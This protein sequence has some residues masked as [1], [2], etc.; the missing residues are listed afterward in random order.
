M[1]KRETIDYFLFF[2]VIFL[3]LIGMITLSIVSA[4]ISQ[5]N[6]TTSH[7]YLLHQILFGLIPGL[8]LGFIAYK[9]PLNLLR[10]ISLLIVILA[11]LLMA[12]VF[13]PFWGVKIGGATR[14]LDFGIFSFQP[15]E[16]L[17]LAFII[18]L[19]SWL[20]GR[21]GKKAKK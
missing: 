21:M 3:I 13:L 7:H 18:Y 6:F 1:A 9:I 5:K 10:R 12:L 11:L 14:W 17:K 15:S 19:S 2:T 4:S 20:A 16:I 8:I